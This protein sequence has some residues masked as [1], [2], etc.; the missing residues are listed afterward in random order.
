MPSSAEY[1]T[2]PYGRVLIP[3]Q[4]SGTFTALIREFPGCV[5]QGDTPAEAYANLEDAAESWIDVA[6]ELGQTIPAPRAVESYGG[7][8]LLRLPRSL[9][10][11]ASEAAERDGTSLNQFI[12]AA[13]A[14]RLGGKA[15]EAAGVAAAPSAAASPRRAG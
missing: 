4:A 12:V 3:D 1:L 15:A 11:E 9:H 7:R 14:H 13:L 6:M 2:R 5:S 10:R 8:V